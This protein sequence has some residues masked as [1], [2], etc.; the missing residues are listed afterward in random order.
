MLH[1][2]EAMT[3][4]PGGSSAMGYLNAAGDTELT[5]SDPSKAQKRKDERRRKESES[6][7][8]L[9]AF[10]SLL[11]ETHIDRLS[12]IVGEQLTKRYFH[13]KFLY[14]GE[15]SPKGWLDEPS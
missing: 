1:I 6:T 3:L 15:H 10:P 4:H 7:S 8:L 2:S 13:R 12:Q 11:E 9:A 5:R 14:T